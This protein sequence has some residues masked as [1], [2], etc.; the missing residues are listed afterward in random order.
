MQW[1]NIR[2]DR[3]LTRKYPVANVHAVI[4][5]RKPDLWHRDHDYAP[6]FTDSSNFLH[7]RMKVWYMLENFK[8]GY[9]RKGFASESHCR[10]GHEQ[11]RE[12]RPVG[13]IRAKF[14]QPV[15][16]HVDT[17]D[18]VEPR[19]NPL[20]DESITAPNIQILFVLRR[21]LD[22]ANPAKR[23]ARKFV[24]RSPRMP[25]CRTAG[26]RSVMN[27]HRPNGLIYFRNF[28]PSA[29]ST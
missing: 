25:R 3:D 19:C 20:S 28:P 8:G 12:I 10:G 23:E 11:N 22:C 29:S 9:E 6:L 1:A 27:F 16:F 17:D 13:D 18:S 14:P 24:G 4:F 26:H 21:S 15:S 7:T 2:Q 5:E